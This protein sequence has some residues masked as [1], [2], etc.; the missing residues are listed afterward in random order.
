LGDYVKRLP[1]SY[2]SASAHLVV[3]VGVSGVIVEKVE[4]KHD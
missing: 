1:T 2:S 4:K 3:G